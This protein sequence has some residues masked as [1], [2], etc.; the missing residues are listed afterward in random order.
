MGR[1]ATLADDTHDRWE[2]RANDMSAAI[3]TRGFLA[4]PGSSF[5]PK[6]SKSTQD[7]LLRPCSLID[8]MPVMSQ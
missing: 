1:L 2:A 8:A 7:S 4:Y 5:P 6:V 3:F